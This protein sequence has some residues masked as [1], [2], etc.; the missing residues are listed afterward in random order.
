MKILAQ[1]EA[2]SL[3]YL[4]Y[5]TTRQALADAVVVANTVSYQNTS[6]GC[7]WF[8]FGGSYSGALSA[9]FKAVYPDLVWGAMSS[10]GVVN[11]VYEFTAFD[12]QVE[13]GE[14][15]KR[16]RKKKR[17]KNHRLTFVGAGCN[18]NRARVRSKSSAR[19][20][21][22]RGSSG[23]RAGRAGSRNVQLARRTDRHGLLLHAR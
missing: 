22:V 6:C 20:V 23:C 2:L 18:G 19:D 12:E 10:S 14:E 9:W 4:P 13:A 11:A 5:L 17:Q 8:A 15:G 1:A 7:T 21:S 16:R 3:E